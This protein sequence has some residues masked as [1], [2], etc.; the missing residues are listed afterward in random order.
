MKPY[1]YP[2]PTVGQAM[3][4]EIDGVMTIGQLV[5]ASA[6]IE[7]AGVIEQELTFRPDDV[8]GNE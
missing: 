1:G 4:V 2:V 8:G 5:A 6:P 3:A 7:H